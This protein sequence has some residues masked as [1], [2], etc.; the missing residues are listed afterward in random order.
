MVYKIYQIKTECF[1]QEVEADSIEKAIEKS[2]DCDSKLIPVD[3]TVS[4]VVDEEST[5]QFN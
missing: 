1:Y 5:D 3:G 4:F 2:D